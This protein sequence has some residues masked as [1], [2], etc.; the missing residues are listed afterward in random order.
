MGTNGTFQW[1]FFNANKTVETCLTI[2]LFYVK[3]CRITQT[4]RKTSPD[5]ELISQFSKRSKN[6]KIVPLVPHF[7]YYA[8]NGAQP[9]SPMCKWRKSSN[10]LLYL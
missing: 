6:V 3:L 2:E 8:F 1:K 10:Q 9:P 7:P 5:F 4:T